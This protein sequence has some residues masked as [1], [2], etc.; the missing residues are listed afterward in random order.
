[1]LLEMYGASPDWFLEAGFMFH[2]IG[3]RH[4]SILVKLR[5]QNFNMD[6]LKKILNHN[7]EILYIDNPK[8]KKLT[9][10]F[11]L[12]LKSFSQLQALYTA[13]FDLFPTILEQGIPFSLQDV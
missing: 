13:V 4:S 5:V 8:L 10:M 11:S 1:M 2:L 3:L 6:S 9:T 7:P 12:T